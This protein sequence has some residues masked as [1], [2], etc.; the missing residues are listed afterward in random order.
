MFDAAQGESV[1]YILWAYNM[2]FKKTPL[3]MTCLLSGTSV[4]GQVKYLAK[5]DYGG[6]ASLNM[7]DKDIRESRQLFFFFFNA[8]IFLGLN[9][10]FL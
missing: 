2:V 1:S 7:E 9:A 6:T 5:G 8:Y 10:L 4:G 3:F